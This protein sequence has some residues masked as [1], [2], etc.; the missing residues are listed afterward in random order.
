[1]VANPRREV[2]RRLT[3]RVRPPA[4]LGLVAGAAALAAAGIAA[5]FE[6]ERRVVTKR[7]YQPGED[8]DEGFFTLRSPGPTLTASDGVALHTEI[9]EVVEGSTVGDLTVVFV[10][11]FALNLDCWHFQRKHLRGRVRT[12]LYDQ[13]SHGRSG[14]SSAK[15]SRIPQL[16]DDLAQVI[17]EVVGSGPVILVGHSM[18]GMT[19]LSLAQSRP[20]LFGSQVMGVALFST[21]AGEMADHSPIRGIPGRAFSRVAE[22]MMATLNRM[23]ELVERGR[24]AGTD[25]SYVVTRRLAFGS[26]VLPSYVEFVGEMLG[27]TSL[28]VIADFYPAFSELDEYTALATLSTIETAVAGGENDAITPITHTDR[29]VE[30]LPGADSRRVANCGHLGMIEHP[31]DFNAVLDDLVIRVE[32]NLDLAAADVR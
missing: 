28:E 21:S 4:G 30:L 12:V 5:G 7:L 29:I 1:M 8:R 24:R 15:N 27:Q 18:G 3:P 2:A 13:R 6:L 11:G 26:Q 20:Q 19:I 32:R 9:D 25:L 17:D 22:P 23:P 14:H 31:D 16:A 10:H